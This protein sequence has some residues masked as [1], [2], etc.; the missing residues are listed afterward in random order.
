MP[1]QLKENMAIFQFFLQ[2]RFQYELDRNALMRSRGLEIP[3]Q[4]LV[5]D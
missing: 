1:G 4:V 5:Y 2:M 3:N